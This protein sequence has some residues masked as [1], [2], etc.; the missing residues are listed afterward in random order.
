MSPT[1]SVQTQS[2]DRTRGASRTENAFWAWIG[3][4]FAN[5]AVTVWIS[6]T[7]A[8][9]V[10]QLVPG[11]AVDAITAEIAETQIT[12]EMLASI[13][14]Y[15]GVDR[16]VWEQYLIYVGNVLRGDLGVS[17]H[18]RMPVVSIIGA[19]IGAT[20]QLTVT[21]FL[22]GL[23]LAIALAV[24]AQLG[25]RRTKAFISVVELL[26]I[27]APTF[28]IGIL[29]LLL[30]SFQL[31][32][33]PSSSGTGWQG[34][35]LP[36]LTLAIPIAGTLSQVL[37]ASLAEVQRLPFALSARARGL[38]RTATLLRHLLRHAAIPLVTLAGT[39]IG[40]LVAGSV[41][42]ENLFGRPGI[43]RITLAAV[44]SRDLPLVMG[45]V[46][47]SAI[48]F[49]LVNRAVDHLYHIID[50]RMKAEATS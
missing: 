8:F 38:S 25:R 16:P 14:A 3:R 46:I 1:G 21:A 32:W 22:G 7:L 27:S 48:A 9:L 40:S 20:L 5:L 31:R 28:W 45:V 41:I 23:V 33:L 30:F 17:Y 43:G 24:A 35:I 15:Y 39:F 47:L 37:R 13:R 29:L 36:S 18:Q 2:P 50:P 44:I 34:L 10:L 4:P 19:E 6:I 11:D 26:S 12:P 49:V 42:V